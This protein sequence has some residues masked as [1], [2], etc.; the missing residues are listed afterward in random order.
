LAAAGTRGRAAPGRAAPADGGAGDLEA[1]AGVHARRRAGGGHG[2]ARGSG[3]GGH[4]QSGRLKKEEWKKGIFMWIPHEDTV[5]QFS[6]EV[7]SVLRV[8]LVHK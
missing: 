5:L 2:R 3:G 7:C 8:S 1:V 6:F 4:S